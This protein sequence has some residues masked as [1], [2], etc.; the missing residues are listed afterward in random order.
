MNAM[1]C[2]CAVAVFAL[3]LAA[4]AAQDAPKPGPEHE[5]LNKQVGT[6]DFTMKLAGIESKGTVVY[7]LDLGGLW[8]KGEMEGSFGGEK[9]SGRSFDSFDPTTSLGDFGECLDLN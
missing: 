3:A 7:K 2:L 5:L 9:F 1:R 8:L 6:W 4:A